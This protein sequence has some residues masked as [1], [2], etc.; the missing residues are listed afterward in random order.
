MNSTISIINALSEMKPPDPVDSKTPFEK[1]TEKLVWWAIRVGGALS[2]GAGVLAVT[3]HYVAIGPW[4]D[5][6]ILGLAVMAL[7]VPL[8]AGF[9]DFIAAVFSLWAL[10]RDAHSKFLA[11]IESDAR[12][13]VVLN[14]YPRKDLERAKICI[15]LRIT[16]IRNWIGLFAGPPDKLA[17]IG[18]LGMAAASYT[19]VSGKFEATVANIANGTNLVDIVVSCITL[20]V[21]A[22]G[23]G[24]ILGSVSLHMFTRRYVYQLELLNVA[25]TSRD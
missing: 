19:A 15:E 4:V 12:H 16:R 24:I 20:L 9:I 13:A 18:L 11:Q 6:A 5:D 17:V 14:R 7:L 25:L 3:R 8:C 1:L 2:A 10:D 22:W 23:T 21:L